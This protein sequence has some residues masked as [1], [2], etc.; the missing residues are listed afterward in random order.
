MVYQFLGSEAISFSMY[1]KLDNLYH[2]VSFYN[3]SERAAL[4][5]QAIMTHT[6]LMFGSKLSK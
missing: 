2:F 4:T 5:G 3:T 6:L 1:F